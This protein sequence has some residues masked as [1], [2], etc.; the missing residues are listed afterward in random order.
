[1][2][3]QRDGTCQHELRAKRSRLERGETFLRAQYHDIIFVALSLSPIRDSSPRDHSFLSLAVLSSS[4]FTKSFNTIVFERCSAF[5]WFFLFL[6]K[7]SHKE[8]RSPVLCS[9]GGILFLFIATNHHH[10]QSCF[11]RILVVTAV[12]LE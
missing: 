2:C 9:K 10:H 12:S 5:L 11:P 3:Q 1:M 6:S 4:S 8:G 7:K